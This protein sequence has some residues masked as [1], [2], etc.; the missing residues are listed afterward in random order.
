MRPVYYF[1]MLRFEF[2]T[3]IAIDRLDEFHK[4]IGFE[5]DGHSSL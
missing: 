3:P 4:R 5:A 1:S 2:D